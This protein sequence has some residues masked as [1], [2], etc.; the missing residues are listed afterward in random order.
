MPGRWGDLSLELAGRVLTVT[1][2]FLPVQ[3]GDQNAGGWAV[4]FL[5]QTLQ[6]AVSMLLGLLP[7]KHGGRLEVGALLPGASGS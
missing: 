1:D 4:A 3:S 7:T 5:W 6:S 2:T